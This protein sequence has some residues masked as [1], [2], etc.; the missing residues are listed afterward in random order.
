MGVG[1][2]LNY[3]G[4]YSCIQDMYFLVHFIVFSTSDFNQARDAYNAIALLNVSLKQRTYIYI[5]IIYGI[6]LCNQPLFK[7][8][9]QPEMNF[10]PNKF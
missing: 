7:I 6:V 8:K 10:S 3:Y 4:I 5:Y 9:R 2:L 1:I